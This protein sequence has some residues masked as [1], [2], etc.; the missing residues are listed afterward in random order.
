MCRNNFYKW[1][2]DPRCDAYC[3]TVAIANAVA[4]GW[5]T[6]TVGQWINDTNTCAMC[7]PRCNFC[8]GGTAFD[9]FSCTANNWLID[10]QAQCISR[11][12]TI[13]FGPEYP[14]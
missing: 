4:L 6:N 9:C 14:C 1:V 8:N 5:G 12:G 11:F 7:D 13:G 2:T 3:P 10:D